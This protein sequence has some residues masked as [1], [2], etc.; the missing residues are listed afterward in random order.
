LIWLSEAI[1]VLVDSSVQERRIFHVLSD[2]DA[3]IEKAELQLKAKLKKGINKRYL[4][5]KYRWSFSDK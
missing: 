3:D 4:I 2:F 1:Q 5:K